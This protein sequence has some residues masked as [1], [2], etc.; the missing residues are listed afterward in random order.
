MSPMRIGL[1]TSIP[2]TLDAFFPSWVEAWRA[3]GYHVAPA[4][5]PGPTG[6]AARIAGSSV[7][8]GVTRSPRLTSG[9]AHR[10]L[11]DWVRREALDVVL[12]STATASALARTA[13][14]G[15]PVVYFCHGLHWDDGLS[16][17]SAAPRAVE[18]A[19][20]PATAGV[21]TLNS[22]DEAWFAAR[23]APG[24]RRLRLPAGVGL[25]LEEWPAVPV[26]D[27][28]RT[29]RLA[30]VGEMS[31]RKRPLDAI[32][33]ARGLQ[34][35]GLDVDLAMLG[36]GPLTDAVAEVAADAPGVRIVG[37]A[38]PQPYLARSHALLHTGAWEGLPRVALEAAATGRTTLGYDVKGVRDAPGAVV[39]GAAG[40]VPALREA[41]GRWWGAG[42][43]EP[44]LERAALDWR[45]AHASVTDLLATVVTGSA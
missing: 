28:R 26:P 3:D 13:R 43:I 20:L 21:V 45:L 36:D 35:A 2:V 24:S 37:R 8:A 27:D 44:E 39:A 17:R 10:P 40:D 33:I 4:S 30:W 11:R 25:H 16:W 15:V 7:V 18:R 31:G 29:F 14:L 6:E 19:L 22:A 5:G 23:L 38:S 12:V 32:E 34:V 42:R 41:V 1:L 9:T